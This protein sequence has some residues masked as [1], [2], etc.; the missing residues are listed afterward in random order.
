MIQFF[1]NTLYLL[2]PSERKS[3]YLLVIMIL[4]MAILEMI[5]VA[6]I[7]PF[8]AVITN[9]EI[10]ESNVFLDKFFEISKIYGV[11]N[12]QEFLILLGVLVFILL[13][14]SLTFK[15]ITT[16]AQVRFSNKFECSIGKRLMEGYLYHSYTWFL[17]RNS[18]DLGKTILSEIEKVVTRLNS[19]MSL[20]AHSLVAILIVILL[21]VVDLKITIIVSIFFS[22][23]YGLIYKFARNYLGRIGIETFKSNKLRFLAVSEA[24]SASKEVKVSGLEENYIKRFSDPAN[25]FARL[26][27]IAS[28]IGKL[29]RF[30]LEAIA[31]GGILLAV[32]YHLIAKKGNFSDAVP[33]ISLY[34]FAGYRLMPALQGIYSCLTMITFAKSSIDSIICE[35]KNFRPI[36]LNQHD[37]IIPFDKEIILK[38]IYYNYPNSEQ[39]ALKNI[40]I[41]IPAKT[42]VGIVGATGSGKTTLVDIILGLLEPQKGTLEV[43][44]QVIT[45][46]N[47][48]SWQRSIGYVPQNIYLTDDTIS[49][50]I[51]FGTDLEN[52]NQKNIE[53]ASKIANLHEFVINELPKK[54]K[55]TVG[56]RGIRLSGGQRQR[57]GIA[58]ALY[59]NPK[60]L[61]LDEATSALDHQTEQVV[62][63]AISKLKRNIT[64]VL[65]AHRLDTVKHCDII[66]KID[67]SK[68]VSSGTYNELIN[69]N[70]SFNIR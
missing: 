6:S 3:A 10:I 67:R 14:T 11:K 7:L 37:G 48:R 49:A 53:K 43:D 27:S 32:L 57:I 5:G 63:S 70:K 33:I 61:I 1:K 65:I 30:A 15:T 20:I 59:R 29:P 66:F 45:K 18:A 24:F 42:I 46:N 39:P 56:E 2:T 22:V 64:I 19:F 69:E 26:Q 16:Y 17:S 34:V 4:I 41:D 60:L 35:F 9:P 40:S 68:V 36:N 58:R 8:M 52:I 38:N 28:V 47:C 13:I 62:M 51:A 23:T 12:K 31:F 55:T 25:T 21:V 54:Y 50:N 44:E